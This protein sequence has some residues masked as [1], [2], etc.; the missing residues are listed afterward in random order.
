MNN[1]QAPDLATPI[2]QESSVVDEIVRKVL[3]LADAVDKLPEDITREEF[4]KHFTSHPFPHSI[5]AQF[6]KA[7]IEFPVCDLVAHVIA[8]ITERFRQV[9]LK[10][11]DTDIK[12]DLTDPENRTLVRPLVE[13]AVVYF[14]SNLKMKIANAMDA[15][16][17]EAIRM[18]TQIMADRIARQIGEQEDYIPLE[19][20]VRKLFEELRAEETNAEH[21]RISQ[22]ASVI[23]GLEFE[24]TKGRPRTWTK[25]GLSQAVNRASHQFRKEKYRSPT[26]DEIATRLNRRYPDLML[27]SGKA[28]GQMLKRY[29]LSWK[30]IKKPQN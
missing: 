4:I 5:K 25:E 29:G 16:C 8:Q 28:L 17:E 22:T 9:N 3:E 23:K 21:K 18:A 14:L 30:D 19:N 20:N 1:E 27:L 7:T 10:F 15:L 24:T 11:K 26:L 12:L 2:D 6:T 13:T